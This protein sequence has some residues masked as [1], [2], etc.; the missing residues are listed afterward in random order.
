MIS[1]KEAAKYPFLRD[2]SELVKIL[3]PKGADLATDRY[4]RVLDRGEERVTEAILKG[5]VSEKVSDKIIGLNIDDGFTPD[6]IEVLSFPAAIMLVTAVDDFYLARRY[7]LSEARR[8]FRLIRGEK[9][10]YIALIGREEFDWNMRINEPDDDGSAHSF[11][12]HFVDFLRNA[13]S[14]R[15]GKWKLV[16]R[17]MRNGYVNVTAMEAARLIQVEIERLILDLIQRHGRITLPTEYKGRIERITNLF[18]ENRS[19]I[20]GAKLP[21]EVR[22]DAFPP[23]M[24]R[25]FES[26]SSGRRA[27]HMERFALTSFLVNAGMDLDRILKL[28]ISATDFDEQL[29]R[30]QVEHIAG[31]RGSRTKYT[32]PSCATLRTHGV[33]FNPDK[34]CG[35]IRH[36]LSYYQVKTRDIKGLGESKPDLQIT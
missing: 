15:E 28:F 23:C 13:A 26:L 9:E 5:M 25:A 29:T 19:K 10:T 36:P 11:A 20:S 4:I 2:A 31:I 6:V 3:Y 22:I 30:Y 1:E 12:L 17:L 16:N 35:K 27:S 7:A 34:L 8:V 32:P 14:F 33:C 24:R 18:E 21:S